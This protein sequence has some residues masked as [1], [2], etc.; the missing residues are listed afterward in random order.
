M[1]DELG[2][3]MKELERL[4]AGRVLI[5]QIPVM[6][7]IDGRCF[8]KFT[9]GME[10]PYDKRM[11]DLM[12]DTTKYLV[13]E[14]NADVGYTQ[15]DEISLAW[16]PKGQNSEMFFNRKIQKIVSS[17]SALASAYFNVNFQNHFQEWKPKTRIPTFDCRVWCVPNIDEAAN[18]FLW[19]E[20]DCVRNSIEMA[21]HSVF[22]CRELYK[23]NCKQ[24][25]SMLYESGIVWEDY[26][27]FFKRGT[28]VK[29]ITSKKQFL[30][31]DE[32][33]KNHEARKN[34]EGYVTRSSVE[35]VRPEKRL[36]DMSHEDRVS[37]IFNKETVYE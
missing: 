17:L 34:P 13:K 22:S 12:V 5:P 11:S 35:T 15:S 10:R 3:R 8:S 33:P 26:P 20:L 21:G 19:R 7:R 30:N 6:A 16:I 36:I 23:K 31:V 25:V 14:S 4:E 29:R 18:V 32:L 37:V 28:Y 24:I 2:D 9:K 1:K 27:E